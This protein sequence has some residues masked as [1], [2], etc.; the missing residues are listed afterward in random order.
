[1]E[2]KL[3]SLLEEEQ[4]LDAAT[5]ELRMATRLLVQDRAAWPPAGSGPAFTGATLLPPATD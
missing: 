2:F 4:Q 3:A 5:M 1:M